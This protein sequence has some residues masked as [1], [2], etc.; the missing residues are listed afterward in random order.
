MDSFANGNV[1]Y[2]IV[3]AVC[4]IAVQFTT[5]F[6]GHRMLSAKLS[7]LQKR[8]FDKIDN[9]KGEMNFRFKEVERRFENVDRQFENVDKQ[10]GRIEKQFEEIE[11]RFEGMDGRFADIGL[12]ITEF[13]ERMQGMK[14]EIDDDL[15]QISQEKHK[16]QD[17]I[18]EQ[19]R[20]LHERLNEQNKWQNDSIT[21]MKKENFIEFSNIREDIGK[22]K[23]AIGINGIMK[24]KEQK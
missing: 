17:K 20:T 10:F 16:H 14:V 22:I 1:V 24:R 8:F 11:R 5:I 13:N 21:D 9:L 7:E 4:F 12:R 6:Y 2:L 15:K 18:S 3:F 19:I 23:G